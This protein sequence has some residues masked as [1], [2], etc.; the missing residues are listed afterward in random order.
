MSLRSRLPKLLAGAA[1][2]MTPALVG[3]DPLP[4]LFR[5]PEEASTYA[6]RIDHLFHLI[7]WIT[8][9]IF[10]LVEGALVIFVVRFRARNRKEAAYLP[11]NN[12]LELIWTAVPLLILAFLAILSQKSWAYIKEQFPVQGVRVDIL[13]EQFDWNIRYPGP[14]GKFDTP[15]DIL[16]VNQMHIP[17]GVPV[18]VRLHSKDVIH[19][20][21]LPEFRIKQDV[22]PGLTTHLWFEA[23]RTG[24]FEIACTQFCG[25]GHYRMRGYLTVETP[26]QFQAWLAQTAAQE[27][28]KAAP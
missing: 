3:G 4:A 1:I 25:L 12:R 10:V 21:F 7:A 17:V 23:R 24:H 22:V 9:V 2:I 11:G 8:G 28:R 6:P 19:S 5:L 18:I 20:F 15:D 27:T 16:T 26:R 14:D 13:A